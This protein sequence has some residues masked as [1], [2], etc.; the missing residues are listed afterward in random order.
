MQRTTN[1]SIPCIAGETRL[2]ISG[3]SKDCMNTQAWQEDIIR[4]VSRISKSMSLENF[5]MTLAYDMPLV[6]ERTNH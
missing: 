5:L 6:S 1:F 3:L 4:K 2:F